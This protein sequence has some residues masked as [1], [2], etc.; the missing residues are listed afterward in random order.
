MSL[1]KWAFIV[2]VALPAAELLVLVLVALTIGWLKTI[3]LFLITSF[4]GI[5]LL[6]RYGRNDLERFLAAFSR[7]GLRA[8]HLETPGFGPMLAGILLVLPGFIT[9]VIGLGLL[10]P[11]ARRWGAAS[12]GRSFEKKPRGG[13]RRTVIDLTPDDYRTLP[14]EAIEQK[15]KPRL[16]P[17]RKRA[18]S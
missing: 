17:R 8:I 2:F 5:A 12:I 16:P 18:S 6:R 10:L 3:A 1:V 9:D 14:D 15:K 13:N 4:L 11:A 7:D